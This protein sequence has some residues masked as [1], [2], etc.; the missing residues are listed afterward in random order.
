M[1]CVLCGRNGAT[2]RSPAPALKSWKVCDPCHERSSAQLSAWVGEALTM[3]A[4]G[5]SIEAVKRE[6]CQ[7]I[8][9]GEPAPRSGRA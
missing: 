3:L 4:R 5:R 8:E 2:F 7:R 9:A 1:F 6:L